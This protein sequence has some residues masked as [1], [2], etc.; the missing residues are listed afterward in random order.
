L[1]AQICDLSEN[2]AEFCREITT[3]FIH[4]DAFPVAAAD[5]SSV[6]DTAIASN[7]LNARPVGKFEVRFE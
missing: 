6:R 2:V 3:G 4:A 1:S 7:P 5:G